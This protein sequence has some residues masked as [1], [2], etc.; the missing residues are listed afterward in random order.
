[1]NKKIILICTGVTI[2]IGCSF[3]AGWYYRNTQSTSKTCKS[4]PLRL[5]GF[6]FTKPLLVC[7]T[8]AEKNKDFLPLK[9]SLEKVIDEQKKIG[10][11]STASV[12][13]QDF[14]N[15]GRININPDDKFHPASLTKVS[16]MTAILKKVEADPTL[17]TA[18]IQYLGKKDYNAGQEI[19]PKEFAKS[20]QFY[21]LQELLD[22]MIKYSDNNSFQLLL[23]LLGN[24]NLGNF[25]HELRVPFPIESTNP[26]EFNSM[27]TRDISYFFKILYNATYLKDNMSDTA[28]EM[29]SQTD[30]NNGIVAGVPQDIKVSHKFGLQT[31]KDFRGNVLYRELND[32]GIIYHATNPY[33]LC[34]MTKTST[35]ID[36]AEQAIKDISSTVYSQITN[37]SK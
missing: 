29:L 37:Y 32:C 2:L 24:D 27:T 18:E 3:W 17:L 23:S 4:N 10:N 6:A 30:F 12:Y 33:L 21:S 8:N 11:I 26:D 36:K 14:G 9:T 15:D 34:I 28:L 16:L 35:G 13:F 25:F 1:M 31:F 7:D 22:M 5:S 20:D 19:K